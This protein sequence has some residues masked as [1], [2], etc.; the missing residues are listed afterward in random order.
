MLKSVLHQHGTLRTPYSPYPVLAKV[1]V[2]RTSIRAPWVRSYLY[3]VLLVLRTKSTGVRCYNNCS[4]MSIPGPPIFGAPGKL[5]QI[6]Y[7]QSKDRII[8][9]KWMDTFSFRIVYFQSRSYTLCVTLKFCSSFLLPIV[10]FLTVNTL[11]PI[12]FWNRHL[13]PNRI[14]SEKYHYQ[15]VT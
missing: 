14:M 8:N 4:R 5:Y 15:I 10:W 6:I 2:P 3:P 7:S 11:L 12:C 1:T 9:A 13:I